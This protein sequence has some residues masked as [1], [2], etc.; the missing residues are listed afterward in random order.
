MLGENSV[1]E[2]LTQS[3]VFDDKEGKYL[4]SFTDDD[5]K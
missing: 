4:S 5:P 1:K 3:Y 2:F